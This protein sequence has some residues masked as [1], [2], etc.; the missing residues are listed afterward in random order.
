MLECVGAGNDVAGP[1]LDSSVRDW[2]KAKS[3]D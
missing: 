1:A 2:G 3:M